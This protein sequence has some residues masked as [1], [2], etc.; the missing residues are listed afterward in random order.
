MRLN[1]IDRN[2]KILKLIFLIIIF[3]PG[4]LYGQ[5]RSKITGT[6]KDA[7]SKEA[8]VGV[9]VM[10]ENTGLGAVTDVNGKFIIINVPV[11]TY[12]IKVSTIGYA[13]KTLLDVVVS[14]DRITTLDITMKQEA[15]QGQEIVVVAEKNNLHKEVSN[16]QTVVTGAQM[17]ETVGIREV[18][19]FLSKQPGISDEDGY[20]T[21]R[22][23]SADQ[24]G[25][26]VNGLNY[27]NAANGSAETSIPLSA[28]EQISLLSGG[29]NA[30]YG[31]FRSGLINITTKTGSKDK[32]SGSFL[33][34]MDNSH[35]RRFGPSFYDPKS[36]NLA[37]YLDPEVAFV[38]TTTAWKDDPYKQQQYDS[39]GGWIEQSKSYNKNKPASQQA[40]PLDLYLLCAWMHMIVPDY[41][42]LTKQGYTVPDNLKKAFSDHAMKEDG[43]DFS[44]DGGFGGPIP[45]FSS[46]LGD[47]TFYISNIS[48]R[49]HYIMPVTLPYDENYTTLLTAKSTPSKKLTLTFTGLWKR[50]IGVSSI[51]PPNGNFPDASRNGGFMKQDNVKDYIR[52]PIYW[53]DPP[54]YPILNQTTLMAGI[55]MNYLISEKTFAEL[56]FNTSYIKD[57]SP[58]GSNR[59]T[60]MI[61]FIGPFPVDEM[62]Y[63]KFLFG[64]H[65]VYG[66][67]YPSYDLVPGV[68][69]RFRGKEGDLYDNI[70]VK[71]DR[72]K[73]DVTSQVDDHH[74]VKGGV[75]YNY[76]NLDH[77]LWEYW[78]DNAYN[79]YEFNYKRTP[80]QTGIY[81]QDQI[82]YDWMVANLGLRADYFY[83][84]GGRWPSGDP[85]A[86][87]A[88]I[89]TNVDSSL[90]TM[91]KQGR[92]L[93]WELWDAYDKTHPGFLQPIKNYFTLSPRIGISFPVTE[94]SK[95][96]F[97][98]GHFR[99]NPPYYSMYLLRYRYTKN[100]LY[101]MSNPNLEPPK[102]VSYELGMAYN[103]YQNLTLNVS[104]YSKD[105]TGENGAITYQNASGTVNYDSWANNNYEDIQGLEVKL[106]KQDNSWLQGWLNFN[107]MLKKSGL[108]GRKIITDITI[109]NS[110]EGLYAAQETRTLP[111]PQVNSNVTFTTPSD[112]GPQI[113]GNNGILGDWKIAVFGEWEAGTYFTWNPLN[114]THL[115]N[116]AEW[117]DYW[118]FD[119]KLSKSFKIAGINTTLN[120]DINN[121]FN[122]KVNLLSKGYAFNTSAGDQTKY[123]A[124]LRLK[125]YD[126]PDY[127]ALRA[128]NPGYYIAGNDKIGDL[129]SD[130]KPYINDPNYSYWIYGKPRDIWFTLK[131]DF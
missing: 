74:Y 2:L 84:G 67:T 64:S 58:V 72:V 123:L 13:K 65:R 105:V 20:M 95:F 104:G 4:I 77:N 38:G 57:Y 42:G 49:K 8:M 131:V 75:E 21:I 107:Y 87:A 54:L 108:T 59:D 53:Y 1:R 50:E 16:T 43:S 30:E 31:N 36:P 121:V 88:F 92:S 82:T 7:E 15:V 125:M 113:F 91:L 106:T 32:Y 9:T 99:S 12:K 110:Q 63:G 124:S 40:S 14:A 66:F 29:Y 114:K 24:T 103:F 35:M 19:S 17:L 111:I 44:L 129:R 41:D 86:T 46:E 85:F 68:T 122:I 94:N 102:T 6:I 118:M 76:I 97:N 52:D 120:V 27:N 73:F 69:R 101:D 126:S 33:L 28:I 112:W 100:G 55:T 128:A 117:P 70:K 98:Y 51:V 96:Y 83:G 60:S 10:I 34:A 37:P 130:D 62:P 79:V 18:N 25:S 109:N 3:L 23:G 80:S 78:N 11:G 115:S 39:F 89:P 71:Q 22:G 93:I 81:L 119:M 45:F 48:T 5:S 61:T 90:F 56:S 127:D 47:A 26:M 116:N